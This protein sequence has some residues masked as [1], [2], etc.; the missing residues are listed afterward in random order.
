M[1][2]QTSQRKHYWNDTLTYSILQLEKKKK[3][4]LFQN[5]MNYPRDVM[6]YNFSLNIQYFAGHYCPA[7]TIAATKYKCPIGTFNNITGIG[8]QSECSDCLGG[9]YCGQPGLTY[10]RTLCSAG[11]YCRRSANISTPYQ[12]WD[13]DECPVGHYCPEGTTEPVACP[14]GTFSNNTGLMNVTECELCTA[15]K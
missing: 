4:S 10:P 2:L 6:M 9:Y 3:L 14:L 15:G 7:G 12:D 13:A 5:V 11:Y 1:P 8:S